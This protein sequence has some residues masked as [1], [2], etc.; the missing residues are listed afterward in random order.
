MSQLSICRSARSGRRVGRFGSL[1][2]FLIL[3]IYAVAGGSGDHP[4]NP[5]S[6]KQGMMMN[7]PHMEEGGHAHDQWVDPPAQYASRRNPSWDDQAAVERG[8]EIFEA[9]C[10]VCH[11][12]DGTGTGPAASGL[13][14]KPADLTSHLHRGPG[15]GD[16]YL[17]W[18]VS[19]GGMVEPFK[20]QGSAMPAFKTALNE[21]QRWDVLTY[22]HRLFH[23]SF[24]G[25]HDEDNGTGPMGRH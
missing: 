18:R 21:A 13:D 23:R 12:V 20:S 19:E 9:Q 14:H 5:E 6:I 10:A 24:Q 15:L 8:H 3:P 25:V 22:V 7:Q 2:F 16:A 4:H 17:Y 11:G 1:L